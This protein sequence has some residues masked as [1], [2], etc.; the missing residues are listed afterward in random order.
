MVV[1]ASVEEGVGTG[2]EMSMGA[3]YWGLAQQ[4]VVTAQWSPGECPAGVWWPGK[5]VGPESQRDVRR[6][7]KD[8]L[9]CSASNRGVGI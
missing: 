5:Y 7:R 3:R 4:H 6:Q 1:I 2:V 8:T 9:R